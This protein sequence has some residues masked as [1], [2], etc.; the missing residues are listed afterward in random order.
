MFV[1]Q[2]ILNNL[3]ESNLLSYLEKLGCS[4]EEDEAGMDLNYWV[5]KMIE[6]NK[7]KVEKLNVFLFDELFYGM[8]RDINVYRFKGSVKFKNPTLWEDMLLKSFDVDTLDYN[9]ILQTSVNRDTNKKI[10]AVKY[11]ENEQGDIEKIQILFV[12]NILMNKADGI[13]DVYAYI[14]VECDV[15]NKMLIIK[16]RRRNHVVSGYRTQELQS[17]I[18]EDICSRIELETINF[19]ITHQ[20]TL[21]KM[22]TGILD[23]LLNNITAYNDIPKVE[24]HIKDLIAGI[25][26]NIN[27]TNI[28]CSEDKSKKTI[29]TKVMD[30]EAEIYK[31]LQG[32][33][34]VD[35]LF[36][37]DEDNIW[38]IGIN[39][40][41]TCIRF[42]DSKNATARLSSENRKKHIFNSKA[43]IDLRNSLE[44]VKNVQS[45]TIATKKD[46]IIK[47]KYSADT[48]EYLKI[49]VLTY[50]YYKKEDFEILWET[51]S[52]YE[53]G[54]NTQATDVCKT[55]VG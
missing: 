22:S 32:L 3:N 48:E 18:F 30:I 42:N 4:Y 15:T 23:D 55:E 12:K 10:A 41:M 26:E 28:E 2:S 50:P 29:P 45:I 5:A 35:Y 31:M 33:T 11:Q 25:I 13:T 8:H 53:D 40:I 37:K 43:F 16:G 39:T 9:K 14:P 7:V 6:E 21:Y 27:L 47:A 54:I 38:D 34:I 24:K 20:K 49:L 36:G 46:K 44:M 1:S 52:K 17:E 19:G 51:Y